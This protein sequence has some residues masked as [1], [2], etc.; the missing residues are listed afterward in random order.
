MPCSSCE[1]PPCVL[2]PG[3]DLTR[4]L[5][6]HHALLWAMKSYSDLMTETGDFTEIN[7]RLGRLGKVE[8]KPT[9]WVS[10]R[11]QCAGGA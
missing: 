3:A 4:A 6:A 11:P 7:E 5:F 1:S 9:D 10:S 8:K 2:C